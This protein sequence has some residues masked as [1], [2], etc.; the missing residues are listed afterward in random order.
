MPARKVSVSKSTAV[1][2]SGEAA[3]LG[4]RT[5]AGTGDQ[6]EGRD[7]FRVIERAIE[8][9]K[10]MSYHPNGQSLTELSVEAD[11]HKAT[12]LRFL[13]AFERGGVATKGRN[14]KSWLLGPAF[15]EMAARVGGRNDIRDISRPIM[16]RLSQEINET[17]QLAV[18]SDSD[19]VYIE[20]V[21]PADM[22]LK[23][24]T[25]IGAR[26]PV[27]CTALGKVL[28]AYLDWDD[29]VDILDKRG[30]RK[31][32]EQ[33]ITTAPAFRDELE[34]IRGDGHAVDDREYNELVVCTAAP[35]RD[36]SGRVVAGVSVSTFGIAVETSRFKELIGTARTAA[37]EL[38]R[39]LG[40]EAGDGH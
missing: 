24:N 18:L 30:M 23:I 32:T 39:G 21:E 17:V 7:R 31:F 13:K 34:K 28:A 20:K 26:R 14:G 1:A 12:T 25:Q 37:A 38:S 8:L 22:P 33:T 16:E 9:L 5:P 2:K 36:A 11:L 27:H 35:V 3:S 29:V 40:F 19:I 4:D 6:S 10:C 15:H